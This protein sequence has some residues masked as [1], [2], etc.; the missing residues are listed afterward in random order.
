V[1]SV[2][3]EGWYLMNTE[4]LLTELARA[5]GHDRSP[6]GAIRLTVDEAL[7][8]RNAG[9]RPDAA[10][11]SLRLVLHISSAADTIALDAKRLMFEPD[12]HELPTWRIEGSRPVNVVPIRTAP[13]PPAHD[14]AW[15]DDPGIAEL[16]A[17]WRD[18]GTVA[19]MAVPGTYRGFVLK[20]ALAL[21]RA[22]L[23]VTPDTVADSIARWLDP[24][25]AEAIRAAL[26]DA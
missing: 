8:Y 7:E 19:G 10:D 24:R 21:R 16:E 26:K 18:R 14:H 5:R 25:E 3:P 12:F 4:E 22:G 1:P 13:I 20:T 23:P 2:L 11:R 15:W 17:E 6:S 9:N